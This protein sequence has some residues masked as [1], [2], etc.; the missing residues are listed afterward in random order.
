MDLMGWYPSRL[1]IR[2]QHICCEWIQLED[3]PFT[4]PFFDGTLA[5]A[6]SRHI[7]SSHCRPASSM[8]VLADWGASLPGSGC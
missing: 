6:S 7:N 4:D 2:Q 8:D 5:R 3:I 1:R